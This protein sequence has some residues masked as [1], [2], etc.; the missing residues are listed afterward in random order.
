VPNDRERE[1]Q[2]KQAERF[3]SRYNI[4]FAYDVAIKGRHS[5]LTRGSTGTGSARNTVVHLFV[6]ESFEEGRLSRDAETY[7]CDPSSVPEY[8]FT[9]ERHTDD[10]G[11]YVP[12]VTCETCLK[13]MERW[14]DAE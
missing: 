11:K 12:K 13:R 6:Q 5:G 7:L 2:R 10:E 3:W 9:E 4:P 14:I 8:Q 1:T